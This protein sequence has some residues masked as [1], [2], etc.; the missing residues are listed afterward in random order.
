MYATGK[1]YYVAKAPAFSAKIETLVEFFPDARIIYL[2]RNPLDMLPSTVSWINYARG[3]FARPG[4][5][6]KY[7]YIDEILDF[8]RH[9]Y[10]HPLEYL[11]SHPSPRHLILNYEDLIQRPEFV[12]HSFY[13]QFGY[14]DKPG[15]ELIVDQAVKETLSFHSDHV[16]SYE[17]MGFTREQ[18]IELFSDIFE[19]FGFDKREPLLSKAEKRSARIPA[20]D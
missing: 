5:R 4:D 7:Q 1:K 6:Q 10:T 8:T 15:L 19:R 14:P 20:S 3:V 12:L 13:E 18:I 2:V 11:D 9:W 16:Y 17:E